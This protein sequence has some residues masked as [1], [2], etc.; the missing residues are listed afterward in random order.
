MPP[1]ARF[2]DASPSSWHDLWI[3]LQNQYG[4]IEGGWR[5]E[6]LKRGKTPDLASWRKIGGAPL[7]G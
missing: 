2:A 7:D 4:H 1:S 3:R 5:F 6:Q